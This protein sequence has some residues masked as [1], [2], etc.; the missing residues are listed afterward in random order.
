MKR[1]LNK[2]LMS[3]VFAGILALVLSGCPST[4]GGTD[5][6]T[7]TSTEPQTYTVTF[8]ADGGTPVPEVQTVTQGGT[9]TAPAAP[10]KT[11]H[12]FGGWHKEPGLTNQWNF[13]TDTVTAD[14][15][16]YA[17]WIYN[18]STPMQYRDMVPLEGRVIPGSIE[19]GGTSFLNA[20]NYGAF[21]AGR[22]VTLSPFK[23]AKHETTY[24]LW[25]EVLQWAIANGYD[26]ANLGREGNDGTDGA[27]PTSGAKTEPVTYISW[28]DAVVWCNAYS[29]M[30]GKDPVYYTNAGYGTVLRVAATASGTS[31][32][33]DSATMKTGV[34][35]Y[36]L[37]TEAEWEYAAR[38]GGEPSTTGPFAYQWAGTNTQNQVV[39]YAWTSTNAGNATHPVGG[40][41]PNVAGL[42]DMSGNVRE[43]CW[44][45]WARDFG[46]GTT[47]PTGSTS[48]GNRVFRGGSFNGGSNVWFRD[49]YPPSGKHNNCGFRVASAN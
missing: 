6:S 14:I 15:I 33:T 20:N 40:K 7:S 25:Y 17:K 4:T 18:F 35:G 1:N 38:G 9:A 31:T 28:R 13:G 36:R 42:Y 22:T 3:F 30:S 48:R 43:W 11:N 47:D 29:E 24:E 5:T 12:T 49:G 21:S 27:A 32:V 16:L 2:R 44:D 19:Y 37:P 10:A 41:L 34:N 39:D 46:T 8:E 26:F 45:W 23:I